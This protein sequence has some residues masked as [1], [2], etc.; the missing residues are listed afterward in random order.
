MGSPQ[1]GAT[2][3]GNGV[4]GDVNILGSTGQAG[5]LNQGGLGGG[6]PMGG[7]QNSGTW[8]LPGNFP[9]G[10]A[11]GAGTGANSATPYNGAPGSPGLVVVRW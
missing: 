9:G 4:A 2:P 5:V 8:G 1:N 6:A 3:G 11:S 10:G 7:C